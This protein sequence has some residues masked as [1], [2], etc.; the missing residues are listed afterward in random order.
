MKGE[1]KH[2]REGNPHRIS[3][4]AKSR[5]ELWDGEIFEKGT[6]HVKV[7]LSDVTEYVR[8]ALAKYQ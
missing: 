3:H 4:P 6:V 1:H 5:C 2:Q 8:P 7:E